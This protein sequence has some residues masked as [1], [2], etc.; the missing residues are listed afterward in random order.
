MTQVFLAYAHEDKAVM[1]KIR[2]SLWREGFTVWT[3]TTD[4]QTG[5]AFE[6]AIGRGIEQADNVVY[7]LSPEALNSEYCQQELNY[8]LSLNKRIIPVLVRETDPQQLPSVLKSLQYIDLTDNVKEEDY[9]LDESQL[10]KILHQQEAYYYQHKVLLVKSLNW[11]RQNRN[12]SILLRGYNLR[13]SEA[14]L[15]TARQRQQHLPTS[16]QEEFI[17]ASLQQPPANSLDVLI[18]YSRA[19]ADLA[20]KLNDALQMQGKTTWF[21]REYIPGDADVRQEI[22]SGIEVSD[23]ILFILSPHAINSPEF[24]DEVEHATALNKRIVT[25]LHREVNPADLHPELGKVQWIDFNQNEADFASTFSQLIRTLDTD[26]E[27]VQNHTKW[28]QRALEWEE[29]GKDDDLL[30]RGNEFAVAQAWLQTA[31]EQNKRPAPSPLQ[32]TFVEESHKAIIA[33]EEAE[34]QRQAELLRLQE[35]K[36]KEAEARLLEQKKS[37]RRQKIFLGTVSV[38]FVISTIL[39]A[40]A[41]DSYRQATKSKQEA[42]AK[43]SEA[44][45]AS[46]QKLDA[47]LEALKAKQAGQKVGW[48]NLDSQQSVDAALQQ[49]VFGAREYNRLSGHRATVVTVA[50]SPDGKT[51]A[52]TS[53]DNTVKLWKREE[54]FLN[55]LYRHQNVVNAVAFSPDGELFASASDDNTINLWRKDGSWYKTLGVTDKVGDVAFSPNGQLIAAASRDKTVKLWKRDGSLLTRLKD[56]DKVNQVAFSPDGTLIA[57]AGDNNTVKLWQQ[58]GRLLATLKGHSER[59][60]SVAFSPDGQFI[61]SGSSDNTVKLWN[62]SGQ[63]LSSLTAHQGP[64]S[65]VSFSPDGQAIASASVDNTIKIWK[66]DGIGLT[67]VSVLDKKHQGHTESVHQVVFSPDGQTIASASVDRTVKLWNRDG[68]LRETF[69]VHT[70]AVNGVAFSPDSQTVVSGSSDRTVMRWKIDRVLHPE[71]LQIEGCNLLGNYL[72]TNVELP[73]SDRRLCDGIAANNN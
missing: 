68:T 39:G 27:H 59:V 4:I 66:L 55:T 18:S 26:R 58:D 22:E 17:A 37:A 51:I 44:L 21:D 30:L 15:K 57:S 38:G 23:N 13:Q 28:L 47:L 63:L 36:T 6:K 69:Y 67:S 33:A 29:K 53:E 20:L 9:Q 19:D 1:E 43:S 31:L 10:I 24:R 14:W 62:R 12:P 48:A 32:Q 3:N 45:Y 49:A 56:T 7:L 54:S 50:I 42:L 70:D 40:I 65:D 46:E 41:F 61:I 25:V 5:E 72:R 34:K 60:N 35:E 52:S 71:K 16:I 11:Q 73:E 64:V 2:N 8:A